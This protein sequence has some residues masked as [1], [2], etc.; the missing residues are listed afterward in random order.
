MNPNIRLYVVRWP[1]LTVDTA[2]I[3]TW[4]LHISSKGGCRLSSSLS[5]ASGSTPPSSAISLNFFLI[6]HDAVSS[7]TLSDFKKSQRQLERNS[8][9]AFHSRTESPV[10]AIASLSHTF[11][12]NFKGIVNCLFLHSQLSIQFSI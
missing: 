12:L 7:G 3:L 1:R 8:E 4:L 5:T 10:P 11:R 9:I 6:E 2:L